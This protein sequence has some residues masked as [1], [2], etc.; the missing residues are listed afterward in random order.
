MDYKK[1]LENAK[2]NIETCRVCPQCNGKAC[3]GEIPGVGGKATG[4]GFIRNYEELRKVKINMDTLYSADEVNTSIELFGKSFKYPVFAAP[5]G[6]VKL[7]YG[8][9]YDDYNYQMSIIEGCK[10]S[11]V[12]GFTGDGVKD[13]A[14]EAPLKVIAENDGWGV[15]TIKPWKKDEILR[16]IKMAEESGAMAVAMDIDAAGLALLGM[17]GKPVSPKSAEEMKE[18]ISS[19]NLPFIFKGIMTVQGARKALEAGAYGIVVSNHGGRVLDE[20]PSTVEVLSEIAKEVKGKMKIFIDGGIRSGLD[21]FKVIALG[22]DAVL[23][24][25][26]Y[27]V[28]VYGGGTE[29]VELYTH[30]LGKELHET[31]VMSGAKSLKDINENMVTIIK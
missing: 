2:K 14:Y 28:A 27:A 23:I 10:N 29:G 12:V 25:R 19:T 7:N 15:P 13:E 9:L 6:A 11:G 22:A 17:Q 1:L 3:R 26:P 31:M 8:E 24:G 16:K 18:I 20:T 5:I 21:I 4:S 30:K